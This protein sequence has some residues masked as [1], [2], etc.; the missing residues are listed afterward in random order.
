MRSTETNSISDRVDAIL[1]WLRASPT[2]LSVTNVKSIF[3]RSLSLRLCLRIATL[4]VLAARCGGGE[5]SDPT[6]V[7]VS[8]WGGAQAAVVCAKVFS[9]CNSA[10]SSSLGYPSQG[11]CLQAITS[12]QQTSAVS[13]LNLGVF[14]YDGHAARRCLDEATALSCG[15]FFP[16]GRPVLSG[17]SCD[18]VLTG[19]LKIGDP[20]G[21][22]DAYCESGDCESGACAV[23]PCSGVSCDDGQYCDPTTNGCV[24]VKMAGALCTSDVECDPMLGCHDNTC[25]PTLANGV[26]CAMST[27]CAAGSCQPA[28]ASLPN[29]VCVPPLADG[30]P[31]SIASE[32][33]SGGCSFM[34]TSG[35][36]VCGQAICAGT[37]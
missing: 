36:P 31:C 30:L 2:A 26:A 8:D 16:F 15:N 9:C 13:L 29:S 24:P 20:C 28:A 23:R 10:D 6:L 3:V 25:S 14:V 27:D 35:S 21:D 33:A 4:V 19:T 32:C 34:G 7:P 12:K 18:E 5:S 37:S 22:L 1:H 17:P 11:A